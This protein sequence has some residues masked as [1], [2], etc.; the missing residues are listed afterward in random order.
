MGKNIVHCGESGNGQ[1]AKICNNLVLGIT[2][3]GVSEAFSLGQHLGL[4]PKLLAKIF[5]TSSAKCWSNDSYNPVP[6]VMENVPASR[7]YAGGFGS[8]LMKKDLGLASSA[9]KI[10]GARLILGDRCYEF[11]DEI[12]KSGNGSKDFSYVFQQL[13]STSKKGKS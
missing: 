3:I 4:D 6:G 1:A 7:G 9:A 10:A 2:M 5:S 13:L 11:Y 12:S 8:D